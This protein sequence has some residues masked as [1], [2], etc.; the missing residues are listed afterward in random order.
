MLKRRWEVAARTRARVEGVVS[1][2]G[3]RRLKRPGT[4]APLVELDF[5]DVGGP[6]PLEIIKGV[7]RI[8][9]SH[10]HAGTVGRS[11]GG[12][13]PG[14]D[15]PEGILGRCLRWG[16]H[17]ASRCHH[18]AGGPTA[19]PWHPPCWWMPRVTLGTRSSLWAPATAAEGRLPP[20]TRR[21][22]D[23]T[24][25]PSSG[26]GV[27]VVDVMVSPCP[28]SGSGPQPVSSP[29]SKAAPHAEPPV[30][31]VDGPGRAEGRRLLARG[32][33]DDGGQLVGDSMVAGWTRSN[34]RRKS[35]TVPM[36]ATRSYR[37]SLSWPGLKRPYPTRSPQPQA[38]CW[39]GAA[40]GPSR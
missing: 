33:R 25:S 37:A 27:R 1:A 16:D 4:A 38:H 22:W 12:R 35:W 21:T 36:R 2:H 8:I 23:T 39:T 18:R 14:A 34:Q 9:R 5:H 28:A 7:D 31:L 40:D 26:P 3:Y 19:D 24:A 10:R 6:C 20:V 15:R 13:A 17:R 29:A 30:A 11:G 32:R